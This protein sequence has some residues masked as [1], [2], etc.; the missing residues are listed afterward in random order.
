M[1]SE[2]MGCCLR[3][4]GFCTCPVA[5]TLSVAAVKLLQGACLLLLDAYMSI[6]LMLSEH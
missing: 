1:A 6:A 5:S 3:L 2:G 4:M